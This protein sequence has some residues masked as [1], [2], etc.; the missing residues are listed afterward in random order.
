MGIY[1]T[2]LKTVDHKDTDQII[3]AV[4]IL[5][6]DNDRGLFRVKYA[7]GEILTYGIQYLNIKK[8]R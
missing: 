1:Y 3:D 5:D 7:D 8:E 2:E 6:V 4:E